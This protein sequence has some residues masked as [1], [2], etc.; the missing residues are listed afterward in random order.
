MVV[1]RQESNM[2]I[3]K[4]VLDMKRLCS[5]IS[6]KKLENE[7]VF[8]CSIR[9][10]NNTSDASQLISLCRDLA[11][12]VVDELISDQIVCK[13]VT[14]KLKT[15]NFEIL[16]RSKTLSSHTDSLNIIT[17]KAVEI[18]K[19]ELEQDLQLPALRLMGVRV[20]DLKAKNTNLPI[21][22][23][24]SKSTTT[25]SSE[26]AH[27]IIEDGDDEDD[28]SRPA[29][30]HQETCEAK[31]IDEDSSSNSSTT[32]CPVCQKML[33]GD[34]DRINKHIDLCLNGEMI[35]TTIKE[36]EQSACSSTK[37]TQT[38]TT[39]IAKRQKRNLNV[40]T[41][42]QINGIGNYFFK[43]DKST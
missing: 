36:Q 3:F 35:R 30:P 40:S 22:Q 5:N 9:T 38:K 7:I 26:V 33:L 24:F 29:S 28:E 21:L 41:T 8:F 6:E 14:L 23:F 25:N 11:K 27:E 19:N 32:T 4:R 37:R 17:E 16:T 12:K 20:A 10:F 2:M 42:T 39:P 34:N 13:R 31:Y 1:V 43:S 18:L 15:M